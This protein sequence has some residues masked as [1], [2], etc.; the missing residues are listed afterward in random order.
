M[1]VVAQNI[2]AGAT[3]TGSLAAVSQA[4]AGTVAITSAVVSNPTSAAVTIAVSIVRASGTTV[5]V[6]PGRAVA[7]KGTDTVPELQRV[8]LP[9]DT[10]SASGAGLTLVVDGIMLS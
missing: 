6:I 1:A 2:V 5:A 9:G 3:L 4:Q 10:I 7:S 8:L